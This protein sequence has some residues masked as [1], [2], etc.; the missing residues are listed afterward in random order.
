METTDV[1]AI[2]DEL[3][4]ILSGMET[5]GLIKRVG[6]SYIITNKGIDQL[7]KSWVKPS[8]VV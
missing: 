8:D 6:E 5:K 4:Q 7:L 3:E 1:E 2:A